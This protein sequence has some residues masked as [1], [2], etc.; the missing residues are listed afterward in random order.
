VATTAKRPIRNGEQGRSGAHLVPF[1]A[2]ESSVPDG[3][4]IE[5]IE[6]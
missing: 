4:T 6:R 1:D 3:S 5:S 2:S